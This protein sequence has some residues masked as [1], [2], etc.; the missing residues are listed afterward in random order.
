MFFY[1][2]KTGNTH[3]RHHIDALEDMEPDKSLPAM[4]PKKYSSSE[5]S[6]KGNG[7]LHSAEAVVPAISRSLPVTGTFPIP[8]QIHPCARG[9]KV[10]VADNHS[11]CEDLNFQ[12]LLSDVMEGKWFHDTGSGEAT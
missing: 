10:D 6:G 1:S 9:R 5:L 7:S 12:R 2:K 4:H 8:D 11:M 3:H